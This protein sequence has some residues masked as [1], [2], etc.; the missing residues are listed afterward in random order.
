MTIPDF[1]KDL[2]RYEKQ[3]LN[4]KLHMIITNARNCKVATTQTSSSNDMILVDGSNH[5]SS[6]IEERIINL[7]NSQDSQLSVDR[8]ADLV[9]QKLGILK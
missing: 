5:K 4:N 2:Y 8:I 7:L 6:L 9:M 3:L 1:T